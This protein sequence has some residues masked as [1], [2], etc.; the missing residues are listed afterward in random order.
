MYFF[1]F[2]IFLYIFLGNIFFPRKHQYCAKSKT[3]PSSYFISLSQTNRKA[4]KADWYKF[5]YFLFICG[6]IC[7]LNVMGLWINLLN[8]FNTLRKKMVKSNLL[9]LNFIKEIMFIVFP[10]IDFYYQVYIHLQQFLN[11]IFYFQ[12]IQ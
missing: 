6:I 8:Y 3:I 5:P 4:D 7:D 10:N 2:S 1:K 9:N 12:N 11:V